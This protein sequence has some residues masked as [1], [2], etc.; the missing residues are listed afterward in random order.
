[1]K[2]PRKLHDRRHRARRASAVALAGTLALATG[3]CSFGS[4]GKDAYFD[5]LSGSESVET[6]LGGEALSQ[7]KSSMRRIRRDLGSFRETLV[8]LGRHGKTGGIERFER[9][10]KPY[11]ATRVDPLI[12]T[13]ESAGHPELRPFQAEL[14]F[15]K[16]ILQH[17]MGEKRALRKTLSQLETNFD[18]M[19]SM[20]VLYPTGEAVTLEQGVA[21]L[22]HQTGAL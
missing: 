14:L 22:R 17:E 3:A 16:A 10:V 11:L 4:P 6:H 7:T 15:S 21:L 2:S 9:F 5:R 8:Q 18:S 1:M 12:E 13:P 19:T 20:L